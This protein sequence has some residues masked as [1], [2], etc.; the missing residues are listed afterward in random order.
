[1]GKTER[2]RY[3]QNGPPAFKGRR[4][5]YAQDLSIEDGVTRLAVVL[6]A[7]NTRYWMLRC[8]LVSVAP[9]TI[10]PSTAN[11]LP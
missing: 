9:L 1:M 4:Y 2:R 7:A 10:A 5:R 8:F 11:N 3:S 6:G